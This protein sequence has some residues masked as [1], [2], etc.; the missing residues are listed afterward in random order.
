MNNNNDTQE[1][2]NREIERKEAVNNI[3]DNIISEIQR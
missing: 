1:D 3:I 2:Y